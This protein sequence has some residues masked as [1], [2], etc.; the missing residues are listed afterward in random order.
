MQSPRTPG[1]GITGAL[2]SLGGDNSTA[3]VPHAGL[4][5]KRAIASVLD[6]VTDAI[7]FQGRHGEA[8]RLANYIA[9]LRA[10]AAR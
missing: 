2:E 5:F 4:S 10:E 7:L 1:A 6:R 8:T 9:D 3:H